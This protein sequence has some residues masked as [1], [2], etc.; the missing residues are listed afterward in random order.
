MKQ[1]NAENEA[2][3]GPPLSPAQALEL[4]E[5]LT[6][7]A[8]LRMEN[9]FLKKP[10]P[11]SRGCNHEREMRSHPGGEGPLR[12]R[13]HV[14]PAGRCTVVVL[15]S[16]HAGAVPAIHPP[17]LAH[18][19]RHRPLHHS[20]KRRYGSRRLVKQLRRDGTP[21]GLGTVGKIMRA[22]GLV[23]L[24]PRAWKRTTIQAPELTDRRDRLK[25]IFQTRTPGIRLVGDITYLRTGEGWLYLAT[26]IDL[27]SRMVVGWQL[28]DHMRSSIVTD[29][30]DMAADGGFLNTGHPLGV[31][32]HTD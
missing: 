19:G 7:N 6:E 5:A 9:E 15:R 8:P 20:H 1:F 13:F 26:V 10:Q 23:A 2:R 11:S 27:C 17:R 28:A 22:E 32:F 21:V 3:P 24:Q 25:R 14:R 30:L 4:K 12:R 16:D 29:A 18:R 31:V